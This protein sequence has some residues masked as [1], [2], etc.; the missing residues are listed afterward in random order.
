MCWWTTP[1]P[2]AT[3]KFLAKLSTALIRL[4]SMTERKTSNQPDLDK[5]LVQADAVA[6]RAAVIE[7]LLNKFI[8]R[9]IRICAFVV[10]HGQGLILS[11]Q[12]VGSTPSSVLTLRSLAVLSWSSDIH[13]SSEVS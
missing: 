9:R 7:Q 5:C 6:R 2:L 10:Q 8:D 3:A 13:L 12:V 11:L 4:K 1:S